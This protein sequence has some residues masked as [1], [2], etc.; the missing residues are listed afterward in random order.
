[1]DTIDDILKV[2]PPNTSQYPYKGQDD[3]RARMKPEQYRFLI[4]KA[5]DTSPYMLF[6]DVDNETYTRDFDPV[7]Y[8]EN[9]TYLD[10]YYPFL[11]LLLVRTVT[12]RYQEIA[13]N[14]LVNLMMMQLSSM[15]KANLSLD[16]IGRSEMETSSRVKKPDNSVRPKERPS[17]PESWPSLVM[18]VGIST[19]SAK[20]QTDAQWWITE[21]EGDVKTVLVTIVN[22][23]KPEII[24]QK[25][26][27][28]AIK[29]DSSEF[30]ATPTLQLQVV[31][32]KP[33]GQS[34]V[35]V[36]N[37]PLVLSFENLLLRHPVNDEGDLV[38]TD[39][40]LKDL[41]ERVWNHQ[42]F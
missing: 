32:S 42:K 41:A 39:D 22:L 34:E 38:F 23:K 3:F 4:D 33:E 18:E 26:E 20:L 28:L 30:K 12:T 25:W 19:A 1:M 8:K 6:T 13:Y 15:D 21:S 7:Y 16:F 9:W 31:M 29:Q 17:T 11:K 24:I 27:P 37:G 14:H 10:S 35:T 2:L 36:E 40:D 5:Q